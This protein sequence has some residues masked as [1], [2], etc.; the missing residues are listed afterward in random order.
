[1]PGP[2]S[3]QTVKPFQFHGVLGPEDSQADVLRACGIP[4]LLDAALAGFHV[5]IFAYGQTGSG[6][7]Y[8]MA[9]REDVLALDEYSGDSTCAWVQTILKEKKSRRTACMSGTGVG[10]ILSCQS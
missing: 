2:K 5:T 4:T 1:M 6:K 7:T 9:G 3:A 10:V 8:T